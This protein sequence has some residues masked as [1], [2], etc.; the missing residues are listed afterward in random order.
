MGK[1]KY[2]AIFDFDGTITTKD[3]LI[4]FIKFSVGKKYYYFGL[5]RLSPMLIK[6]SL[7][8]ISNNIAK[9]KM[10][11]FFFKNWSSVKFQKLSD[12]YSLQK[13]DQIVRP[14]AME[15]I[16][17]HKKQGHKVIIVSASI[18]CWLKLWCFKNDIFLIGTKL[19]IDNSIL[20]G[21][22]ST[23]NC[24]GMEKVCR[25][26]QNFDLNKFD[27]IYAYGDSR[28]DRQMLELAD[29]SFYKF[30]NKSR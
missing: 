4:D 30:F 3:S 20:T 10:I 27:Y 23:K 11:S 13:I 6:Y 22:F 15:R 26:K 24:Y 19:E 29:K 17:W 1:T 28:G 8:I 9:E 5:I 14:Y 25:I 2:I 16:Q 21:K 18:E 7:N 12:Q